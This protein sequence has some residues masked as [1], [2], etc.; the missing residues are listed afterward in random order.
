MA[1]TR[2]WIENIFGWFSTD[3]NFIKR[4]DEKKMMR[5]IKSRQIHAFIVW[6][7][8]YYYFIIC[9]LPIEALVASIIGRCS[10]FDTKSW[11]NRMRTIHLFQLNAYFFVL[12]SH[13]IV[14]FVSQFF[15]SQLLGCVG[16]SFRLSWTWRSIVGSLF[17]TKSVWK[18][19]I[20]IMWCNQS[21]LILWMTSTDDVHDCENWLKCTIE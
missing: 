10:Y 4:D 16:L 5:L 1:I 2:H 11:L 14:S 7:I 13:S 3:S 6:N 19:V 17:S 8:M 12:H 20:V 15:F 9:M 21:Q 18:R